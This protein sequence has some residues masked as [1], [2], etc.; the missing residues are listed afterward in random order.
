MVVSGTG[1][2]VQPAEKNDKASVTHTKNARNMKTTRAT[3]IPTMNGG[4]I[5]KVIGKA[6]PSPRRKLSASQASKSV[7]KTWETIEKQVR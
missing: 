3:G 1:V 4:K 6:V 2:E 5:D 7:K